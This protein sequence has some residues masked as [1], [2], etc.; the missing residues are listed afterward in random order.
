MAIVAWGGLEVC[1]GGHWLVVMKKEVDGRAV[2]GGIPLI[3]VRDEWVTRPCHSL[4][5]QRGF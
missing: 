2:R 4:T 1:E 3:G 5:Q